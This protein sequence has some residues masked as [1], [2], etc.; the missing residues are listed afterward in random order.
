LHAVVSPAEDQVKSIVMEDLAKSNASR[1]SLETIVAEELEG[2]NLEKIETPGQNGV[3]NGQLTEPVTPSSEMKSMV[4]TASHDLSEQS[5]APTAV[6]TVE[7][8]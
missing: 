3:E 4:W 1:Q 5:S 8:R 6:A 2:Q 7:E